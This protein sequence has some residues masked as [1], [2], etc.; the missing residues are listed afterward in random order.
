MSIINHLGFI[1]SMLLVTIF[2]NQYNFDY[3]IISWINIL[4]TVLYQVIWFLY[5]YKMGR[6]KNRSYVLIFTLF[7]MIGI[8][9]NR[10]FRVSQYDIIADFLLY[11]Y[12]I[13]LYGLED[14]INHDYLRI[15]ILPMFLSIF[16][17]YVGKTHLIKLC[18][19]SKMPK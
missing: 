4:V 11:V 6:E 8:I 3:G 7:W 9:L 14:L 19:S 17:Y 13:P 12:R 10:L 1:L 2:I 15:F 16:G 18:R 5:A